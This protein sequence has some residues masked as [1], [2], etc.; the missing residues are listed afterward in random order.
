MMKKEKQEKNEK[1]RMVTDEKKIYRMGIGETETIHFSQEMSADEKEKLKR[2]V[3][4]K[5]QKETKNNKKNRQ[6]KT[7]KIVAAAASAAI[8]IPSS[9]YAADKIAQYFQSEVNK[10]GYQVDIN[11]EKD[12]TT[13]GPET[14][15]E[16]NSAEIIAMEQVQPVVLNCETPK[17]YT[18]EE[19]GTGWY[20]FTHEQGFD[21]GKDFAVELIRVDQTVEEQLFVDDVGMQEEINIKGNNGIYVKFNSIIGS[22]Y[23]KEIEDTAYNQRIF[24]FDETQGYILQIYAMGGIEKEKL[25]EYVSNITLTPCQEGKESSFMLLSQYIENTT[26]ETEDP[27]GTIEAEHVVSSNETVVVNG[28]A[29]EVK[30]VQV[31]DTLASLIKEDGKGFSD[32]NAL[33]ENRLEYSDKNGKL[34][35]YI[36]E[37]IKNGDGHVTPC[38]KVVGTKEVAQRFV[39]V[40]LR[41][42]NTTKKL[43]EQVQVCLNMDYM[44][45]KNGNYVLDHMSYCRPKSVENCQLD[46]MPQY[47]RET[48]GGKGFY[49]KDLEPGQEEVYHIGYFVDEDY[50]DKMFLA[51]NEG[52]SY[53]E[54]E[55]YE[56]VQI[57]IRQ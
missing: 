33:W 12:N 37:T 11:I 5:M 7:W 36:R 41:V 20:S 18:M 10:D 43:Q 16:K 34:K 1:L 25:L 53:Q 2:S 35:S 3:L 29:Y 55:E 45:E 15:N 4:E 26:A 50:T 21:A 51:I 27:L 54:G 46:N 24:V 52:R 44:T 49:L 42:K 47:F 32:A 17:G 30:E 23:E 57:D 8:I 48:N 22:R 14:T 39:L 9:A 40:E 31:C 19:E 56:G 38:A 13:N 6:W 28:I